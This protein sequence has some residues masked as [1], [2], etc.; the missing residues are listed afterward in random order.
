[1]LRR[2]NMTFAEFCTWINANLTSIQDHS[3]HDSLKYQVSETVK[4]RER[5]FP[6][7]TEIYFLWSSPSKMITTT[8]VT[9]TIMMTLMIIE[10]KKLLG[11]LGLEGNPS[12]F[13]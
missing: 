1:M 2:H 7:T 12:M 9:K 5:I 4:Q 3:R 11:S 6:I 8:T 13:E 10:K